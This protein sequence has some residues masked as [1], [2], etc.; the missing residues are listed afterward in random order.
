[1]LG[2]GEG[3]VVVKREVDNQRPQTSGSYYDPLAGPPAH[4]HAQDD[5]DPLRPA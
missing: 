1:M 5:Y 4:D 3:R 2:G